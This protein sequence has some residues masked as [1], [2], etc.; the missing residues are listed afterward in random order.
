MAL[1][2]L[3]RVFPFDHFFFFCLLPPDGFGFCDEGAFFVSACFFGPMI[4]CLFESYGMVLISVT[5]CSLIFF[6]C[7]H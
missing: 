3:S 4:V 1:F 7:P 6:I 2:N 5:I